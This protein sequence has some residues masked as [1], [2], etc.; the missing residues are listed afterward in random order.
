MEE[1]KISVSISLD[2]PPEF[3][4]SLE[5]PVPLEKMVRWI[6]AELMRGPRHRDSSGTGPPPADETEAPPQSPPETPEAVPPVTAQTAPEEAG[7][8]LKLETV[9]AA[10]TKAINTGKAN[11]KDIK[12]LI[13]ALGAERLSELAEEKL[14]AFAAAF[15]EKFG[16]EV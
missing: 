5:K 1:L 6:G 13:T 11:V 7:A 14:P 12:P 16:V 15:A 3:L 8:A 9:I 4:A 10:V 2:F